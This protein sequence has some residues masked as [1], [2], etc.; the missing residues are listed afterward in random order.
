MREVINWRYKILYVYVQY[1]NSRY[2]KKKKKNDT[3]TS[4]S[5]IKEIK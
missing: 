2:I 3:N 5:E 4:S 1:N